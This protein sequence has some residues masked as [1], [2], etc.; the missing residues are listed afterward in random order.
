MIWPRKCGPSAVQFLRAGSPWKSQAP[1]R[2]ETSRT[3]LGVLAAR[4]LRLA[5]FAGFAEVFAFFAAVFF[6]ARAMIIAPLSVVQCPTDP[7]GLLPLRRMAKGEFDR[8]IRNFRKP[9]LTP[10][11]VRLSASARGEPPSPSRGE[12]FMLPRALSAWQARFR[13][14]AQ[15]SCRNRSACS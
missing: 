4:G 13:I 9:K 12:G 7:A 5:F 8:H 2:V 15:P 10:H 1:L 6:F 14:R 11:A 3:T